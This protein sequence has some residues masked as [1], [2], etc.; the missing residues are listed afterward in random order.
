MTQTAYMDPAIDKVYFL[1]VLCEADCYGRNRGDIESMVD[2]WT[3][4]PHEQEQHAH[5][6]RG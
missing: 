1:A 6:R 4:I 2:S 5:Q 3:V